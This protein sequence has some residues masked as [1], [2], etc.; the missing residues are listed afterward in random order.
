MERITFNRTLSSAVLHAW[1]TEFNRAH[2]EAP[3]NASMWRLRFTAALAFGALVFLAG[4]ALAETNADAPS[5]KPDA[6]IDL[7]TKEGV[8]VVKGRWR[9]SDTEIIPIDFKAAGPDK[10]PTGKAIKTYDF[11]PHAGGADFND[12]K[13]EVLD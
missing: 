2:R 6:V 10:Q 5:G 3:I 11:M 7:A 12:L 8:D 4:R 1:A 9:Y 13:W